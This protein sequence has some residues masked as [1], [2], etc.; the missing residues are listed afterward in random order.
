[1]NP[2]QPTVLDQVIAIA[3]GILDSRAIQ[4]S[5]NF[6]EQGGDSLAVIEFCAQIE[7]VLGMEIPLEM[8]WDAENFQAL[9][10][11]I[12]AVGGVA[13]PLPLPASNTAGGAG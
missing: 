10:T 12:E 2:D 9:A 11:Q 4:P 13:G 6:F 5:D 8:V 7:A 3:C 1:V